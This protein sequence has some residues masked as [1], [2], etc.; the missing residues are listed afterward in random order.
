MCSKLV[1]RFYGP[2]EIMEKTG[3]VAYELELPTH[4]RVHNVFHASLLN[5]Y[6]YHTKHVIHWSLLQ[7]EPEE[8]VL[9]PGNSQETTIRDS[10]QSTFPTSP[11]T[12]WYRESIP[13][14]VQLP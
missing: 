10:P 5:K 14:A 2:F 8:E 11:L 1:P 13:F 4:I 3:P 7:V 12:V 6:V 9:R